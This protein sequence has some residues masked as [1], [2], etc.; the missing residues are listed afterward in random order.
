MALKGLDISSPIGGRYYKIC[1]K[2]NSIF[3]AAKE[4]LYIPFAFDVRYRAKEIIDVFGYRF[5][6]GAASLPFAVL[7]LIGATAA[8]AVFT[9][10]ALGAAGLW[11][12][13]VIPML[14]AYRLHTRRTWR[15]P[16][17]PSAPPPP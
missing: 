3:R 17:P 6:K 8:A 2:A 9:I 12:A 1:A 13:L 7:N 10:V 14:A 4:M 15:T 11:L 16:G 5:G